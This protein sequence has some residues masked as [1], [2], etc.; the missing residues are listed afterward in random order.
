MAC[1]GR[2]QL[3]VERGI[4]GGGGGGVSHGIII[5]NAEIFY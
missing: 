2:G 3:M 5:R 1:G 4:Q